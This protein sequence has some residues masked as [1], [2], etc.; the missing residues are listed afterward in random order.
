LIKAEEETDER[1]GKRPTDRTVE[2]LIKTSLIIV[3]KHR[4]PTSQ[5][6]DEWVKSIFKVKKVGHAGTLVDM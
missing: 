6:I 2:E 4:G 5:K 3:D 1:Y